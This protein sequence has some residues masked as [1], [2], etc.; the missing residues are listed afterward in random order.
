MTRLRAAMLVVTLAFVLAPV[1]RAEDEAPTVNEQAK[2]YA[3]EFKRNYKKM[4]EPE[5]IEALDKLTAYFNDEA[6]DDEGV[7]DDVI[8]SMTKACTV[9]DPV[10]V[11][12]V[13]KKFSEL[14]LGE[15]QAVEV[16]RIVAK[17]L[18]RELAQKVPNDTVYEAAF[19]TLAKLHVEDRVV[20]KQL[21]DLLNHKDYPVIA[22]AA[23]AIAGY[24][25]ANGETR[26]ELFEEV[27]KS[28]EGTYSAAQNN[29][30]NM[31]R[32][33]NVIGDDVMEALVKLSNVAFENPIQARSWWG[34]HK[35]E[36]WDREEK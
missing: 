14:K 2:D 6:V 9:R 1:V 25:G 19:E 34:D 17:V 13:M 29:D 24:A 22:R 23:R 21:T 31:K 5:Q 7:K 8:E 3:K 11:A 20:I 33:W 15:K 4:S 18:D 10:V 30:T 28:S 16:G 27:L 35:K 32:K 12:H 36:N 26:K